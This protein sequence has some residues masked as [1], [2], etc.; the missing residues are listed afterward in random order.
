MHRCLSRAAWRAALLLSWFGTPIT[1]PALTVSLQ[2]GQLL[3][4]SNAHVRLE[5]HLNAGTADFYWQDARKITG[6]YA[7]VTLSSGYVK[8]LSFSNRTYAVVGSNEVV[9]TSSALGLPLMRQHFIFDQDDSF[10]T[11]VEMSASGVSANWMGPVVVDTPGGVDLGAYGDDR[12]LFVSFDNDHFIRYNAMP[13]NSTDTGYEVAAFYD[14]TTRFGLVVGSV[15]HDTWK[16]GVYWSGSNNKLDKMNVFGGATSSSVTWDVMPHGWVTGNNISSPTMFVG[17]G[18]D[19]RDTLEAFA[20]ENVRQMPRL[21]WT[22]GVPF[23]WNSWGYYQSHINYPLAIGVADSIRTN[24][25]AFGFSNGG[26]AYV[27]LDSYWD[28]LSDVQLQAFASH[29]HGN[30]QKAGIYW[31]PFVWW[32]SPVNATNTVVEGTGGTYRYSEVLLR[33]TTGDFQSNDGALAMDPT[34]PGTRQRID[35]Y[36]NRFLNAGFDYIKLD[37]L[38]HGALEGVH[39][40]PAVMTGIQAYNQGMQYLLGRLNGRMF[41][42]ESI[43]PLFPY[44]YAHARRIACDAQN[45]RLSDTAYTM[46][47]VTYGW[48]LD[49]LYQFNDPDIMVFA[50]GATIY[51]N[52]S[53]VICGAVTGLFLDGDSLSNSASIGLAQLCL[54]N[55]ALNAVD[56]AGLTF[57]PVEGN[58]G[59]T[60]AQVFVRQDGPGWYLAVFNYGSSATNLTIAL[61]R[62]GITG[63][64]SP[65]DVWSGAVLPPATLSMTV[66]LNSAQARLFHLRTR[67]SLLNPQVGGNRFGFSVAGDPDNTYAIEETTDWQTWSTVGFA[68]NLD[69]QAQFSTPLGPL[70]AGYRAR[71][72]P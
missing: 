55:P 57:L 27:N 23:G 48:W 38:S 8:G 24:L 59:S 65:L 53:R 54:T 15:T 18:A 37:F 70:R 66:A 41:I 30:G 2:A 29:C 20:D 36:V 3:V 61:G 6:S 56:R 17:F 7:G 1:A 14:N 9:V 25:Q 32:G 68:T 67:P 43:A 47:S 49:R 26:A 51:E 69:G 63:T 13:L 28:N 5:Y 60:A 40:D 16:S 52:Q 4:M 42:S 62:A 46:N 71:L 21:A 22:N 39:H 44:Q 12:A 72:V 45:S 31:G 33:T 50:N 64:F 11:R 35:Y 34:H 19:W 58:T 10:L